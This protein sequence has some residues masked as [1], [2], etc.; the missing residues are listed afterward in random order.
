[1]VVLVLV[2]LFAGLLGKLVFKKWHNP[3]TVFSLLWAVIFFLYS[4]NLK[5]Y[6]EISMKTKT[7][8]FLQM[9]GFGLGGFFASQY[10]IGLG[11]KVKQGENNYSLRFNIYLVMCIVSIVVLLQ[12]TI[13]IMQNLMA[14]MTFEDM[15]VEGLIEENT[16]TGIRVFLKIFIM[17]PITYS[18]SAITASEL[19]LKG[20]STKGQRWLL[21]IFN[22]VIILLYSLQHGARIMLITLLLTY[23]F[24]YFISG[25][26]G[27]RSKKVKRLIIILCLVAV[28]LIVFMSTSRG[29]E[30]SSLS[31]SVYH[32]MVGCVPH[33]HVVLDKLP[34]DMTHTYGFASLNG[35]ISPVNIV[36]RSLG[37]IS[38]S[39]YLSQV[40][41]KFVVMPEYPSYV[42]QGILMNAFVGP[43][44]AFYLDLG[45][46]GV[47]IGMF[48][49][50]F[51]CTRLYKAAV[52]VD[53]IRIRAV[54]LIMIST[55]CVGF[56]RLPFCNYYVPLAIILTYIL[57]ERKKTL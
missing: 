6:Y 11:R 52:S 36:L 47:L 33:L 26:K 3:V 23:L 16:T 37:I 34:E 22:V 7:I 18:I 55:I 35:F 30:V 56:M 53:N 10:K 13:E 48:I 50:G 49:Y 41:A 5:G 31:S 54:Y 25:K 40:A 2:S 29:I 24:A 38:Q 1:M 45:F 27:Y 4:L 46:A 28:G 17:F 32:Y 12:D 43:A 20:S 57:Y 8:F 44:Y 42:G 51:I 14:G 9:V 39:P 19:L 21:F 15:A